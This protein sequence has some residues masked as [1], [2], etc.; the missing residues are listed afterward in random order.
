MHLSSD[1][2]DL[3]SALSGAE[4][5]FLIVGAYAVMYHTEPRYTKDLDIWIEPTKANARRVMAALRLFGAPMQR[6][7]REDLSTPGIV[8][9]IGVEPVRVDLLT[10]IS[11][12][13][14]GHAY[15][16]AVTTRYGVSVV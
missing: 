3:I 11:G 15:E 9:Q 6:I 5:R 16:N 4:A 2:S 1:F 14:F 13:E 12:L 8:Y 10:S 7:S